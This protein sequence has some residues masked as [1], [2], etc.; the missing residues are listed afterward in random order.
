L[1]LKAATLGELTQNNGHYVVQGHSR[2]PLLLANNTN[3]R[4]ISHRCQDIVQ[5]WSNFAVDRRRMRL[6]NACNPFVEA[7]F[8][9][10]E[11]RGSC[12]TRLGELLNSRLRNFASRN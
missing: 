9:N 8:R 2:S 10:P 4:S 7:K 12:R 11:F 5:Y 1:A 6:F 3:L